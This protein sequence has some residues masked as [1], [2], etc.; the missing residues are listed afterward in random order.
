MVLTAYD[1]TC[2]DARAQGHGEAVAHREGLTAAAMC[3]SAM[4]GIEDSVARAEVERLD[5]A[6][7]LAA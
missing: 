2:Q 4:T 1:E 7:Q 5:L 6:K 3:L